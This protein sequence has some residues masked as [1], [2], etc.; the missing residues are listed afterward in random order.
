MTAL[1]IVAAVAGAIGLTICGAVL[2]QKHGLV[3]WFVA[4]QVFTAAGEIL[5]AAFSLLG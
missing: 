3:G 1:I 2:I 4:D 5:V